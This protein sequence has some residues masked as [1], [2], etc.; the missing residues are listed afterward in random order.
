MPFLQKCDD[1]IV[2]PQ[3]LQTFPTFSEISKLFHEVL[4]PIDLRSPYVTSLSDNGYLTHIAYLC[5]PSVL[6][7]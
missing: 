7:N 3:K 2:G 4:F 1:Y 5:I 6:I